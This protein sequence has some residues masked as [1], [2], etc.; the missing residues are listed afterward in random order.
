MVITNSFKK[1]KKIL[2]ANS[3]SLITNLNYKMFLSP[4]HVPTLRPSYVPYPV[5][6]H[7]DRNLTLN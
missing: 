2:K 7:L 6:R 3:V 1:Q 4:L 5:I